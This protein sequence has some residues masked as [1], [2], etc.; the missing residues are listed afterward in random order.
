MSNAAGVFTKADPRFVAVSEATLLRGSA[1]ESVP[2]L[3]NL[4]KTL[5]CL[6][7]NGDGLADAFFLHGYAE[8]TVHR[9]HRD[10]IVGEFAKACPRDTKAGM[11]F[12][13]CENKGIQAG[14]RWSTNECLLRPHRARSGLQRCLKRQKGLLW[15]SR[16]AV[17]INVNE[18]EAFFV[19]KRPFVIVEQR[20]D[21][22]AF[23]RHA[24]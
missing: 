4:A 22:I 21:E 2:A 23:Y 24:A 6:K 18:A 17:E 8:E 9:C 12:P 14:I 20:P 5:R 7:V 3:T 19:S 11:T 13:V 16:Q 15:R 1:V 10:R